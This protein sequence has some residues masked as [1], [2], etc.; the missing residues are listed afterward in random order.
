[1]I[2]GWYIGSDCGQ[3]LCLG[4]NDGG[5]RA[6]DRRTGEVR[7]RTEWLWA[8]PAGSLLLASSSRGYSRLQHLVLLDP[9]TGR[10]RFDLGRW[11]LVGRPDGGGWVVIRQ[12][13]R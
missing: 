7:W 10:T 1:Q 13:L 3:L 5:V 6:V 11:G 8:E 2:P 9:A 4:G 12:D